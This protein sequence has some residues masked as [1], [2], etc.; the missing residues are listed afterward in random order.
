MQGRFLEQLIETPDFPK[1]DFPNQPWGNVYKLSSK[2]KWR[3]KTESDYF[4]YI[5]S[6]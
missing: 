4:I 5:S 1:L 2:H 3:P 6:D